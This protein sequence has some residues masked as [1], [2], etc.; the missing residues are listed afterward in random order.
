MI[1]HVG[2]TFFRW[3]QM[4][5]FFS[6]SD[7]NMK[8]AFE[9]FRRFM[10]GAVD[11]DDL[12]DAEALAKIAEAETGEVPP[13]KN[14]RNLVKEAKQQAK[15]AA[16]AKINRYP[17]TMVHGKA[18]V[19]GPHC[20]PKRPRKK[21][22]VSRREEIAWHDDDY[23]NDV[24][25]ADAEMEDDDDDLDALPDFRSAEQPV[26]SCKPVLHFADKHKFGQMN[27][28]TNKAW[29]NISFLQCF[30]ENWL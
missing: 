10:R 23:T 16:A 4:L 7:P 13:G 18:T 28:P 20:D 26:Q 15:E 30:H 1:F 9:A 17:A 29:V 24:S 25:V 3:I 21:K 11:T 27:D 8:L 19:G 22:K 5:Q 2:I 14:R 6:T 12:T